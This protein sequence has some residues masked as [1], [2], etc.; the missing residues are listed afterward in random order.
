M[1]TP[2]YSLG[3]DTGGTFTDLVL[4]DG[5]GQVT[6]EKAFSTPGRPETAVLDVLDRLA[7]RLGTK[8]AD[9]LRETIRFA[10]G[11]TVST[12]ALIQRKGAR[13]GLLTTRGFEDTLYIARGPVG[14]AGGLPPAQAMDFIHTEPPEPLV[15]KHLTI[16][17]AERITVT[18]EV[19]APLREDDIRDALAALLEGQIESLAVC[20]LWSFRNPVHEGL[21][22]DVVQAAAPDLPVSLSSDVAPRMGEFERMVTAVVNAYIGPTTESYLATLQTHLA[23]AGLQTPLQIM[24]SSGGVTLPE[25]VAQQ[26]VSIINSGPIGGLIAAR[27]LGGQLGHDNVITADMG[28][29]SFDVGLIADGRFEEETA[30]FLDQG[31]PVQVPSIKV[32][33]I[34]AGGGSIAWSDG[35]RLHVGPQSAGA[36]PGPA[37]YGLGGGDQPTVTD[38]LVVLGI[39]DP[40]AFFG[41]QHTLDRELAQRAIDDRIAR[42]LGLGVIDAAAGIYEL[43]TAKLGD[44]IRKVSVESGNDPRGF[45]LFAYG[46]ACGAH[47]AD[48]AAQLGIPKVILPSAAP[49]F[50]ALGIDLS[51]ILYAHAKSSPVDLSDAPHVIETV[52]QTFA[53]LEQRALADMTASRI[54]PGGIG[55]V[56]K[57]DM[58]YRGQMNEVGLVWPD[59]RLD[60]DGV[61]RLQA[62]F[63]AH[64]QRRFGPGTVRPETP[65][66]LIGFRVEAVKVTD[67]PALAPL[68]P[69]VR[70]DTAPTS[71]RIYRRDLGW[72][73]ATIFRFET[74]VSGATL[75]GPAVIEGENTTVWLPP[76]RVARR[77]AYGNL[78]ISG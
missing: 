74:L 7:A 59:G 47:C 11:T 65:L 30:P 10:H 16:G 77:D 34:G 4:V 67:K 50:S 27:Y 52:N 68:E 14:R 5:A 70:G 72:L 49:V 1:S 19:L 26:A 2:P 25:R 20:L 62:A 63:E 57:I 32:V 6:S 60:R 8:T 64:Y 12:N 15:P 36:D 71:R 42:P 56:H 21:V 31:L 78:E 22:R 28:G 53:E 17:L 73:E 66:E 35:Y 58:R 37:C 51:D 43:V 69:D 41:G 75:E 76:Q 38:A 23:A 61:P 24:K 44:L 33:T 39:I 40:A 9:L 46:G 54:A 45:C 13:V 3:V 55:L 18:G 29:T 48:F